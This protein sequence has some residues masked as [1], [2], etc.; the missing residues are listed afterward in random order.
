MRRGMMSALSGSHETESSDQRTH[1]SKVL[2]RCRC[3]STP[4]VWYHP[5]AAI[6]ASVITPPPS[7]APEMG[8]DAERGLGE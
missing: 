8:G 3:A 4:R 1:T 5:A 2:P 6:S 7:S